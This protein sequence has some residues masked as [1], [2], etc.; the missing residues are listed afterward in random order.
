MKAHLAPWVRIVTRS[1]SRQIA[2]WVA[3]AVTGREEQ[4]L[5]ENR[6][7]QQRRGAGGQRV[8]VSKSAAL[9]ESR[10]RSGCQGARAAEV[11]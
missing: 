3:K 10:D 5:A 8:P 2:S 1:G 6:R 11:P 9:A 4:L 7:L